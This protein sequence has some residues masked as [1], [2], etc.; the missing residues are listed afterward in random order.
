[1]PTLEN[2]VLYP[3]RLS[4]LP[5]EKVWGGDRLRHLLGEHVTAQPKIGEA[6]IAWD[7][8]TIENGPFQGK[9]LANLV[10]SHP[11]S[12]LGARW[13]S[14]APALFPLLVKFLDA[15]ETLSV[16]VH[17][18]D[19]YARQR[20]G[21]PFGKAEMW[22]V[23]EAEPGSALIHGVNRSLSRSEAERAVG[24]GTLQDLL[25]YVQVAPGDVI[26]NPPGTI[27]AVGAGLLLY[28][29]QQSSDLTYRFYDW[30]RNDPARE[31]H[32][33]KALDVANLEPNPAHK[34]Q[35]IEVH[36]P[37][38]TRLYLGAC[39]AFAAELLRV[40]ARVVECPAGSCFHVLTAIEGE[41]RVEFEAGPRGASDSIDL[42]PGTTVLVPAS[43]RE[44]EIKSQMS[45]LVLL[46]AYVPD[47][48]RDVLNPLRQH[49][50]PEASILRLG[51]DSSHNDLS[52]YISLT[53]TRG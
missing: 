14:E 3:L 7:G 5:M 37:G 31:L 41:G 11:R 49:G 33:Q 29:L 40:H 32:L 52:R 44:Y 51:G 1:M 10:E 15:R 47:L 18:D 13:E 17:P 28:E 43:I 9:T 26:L 12:L 27:H 53:L 20:E 22:L 24:A 2:D 4:I 39:E 21:E 34:I 38:A 35:P 6:W 50:I 30:D 36:E 16:Q 8:L 19:A 48:F 23:L 46:K 25:E 42:Q 45:N